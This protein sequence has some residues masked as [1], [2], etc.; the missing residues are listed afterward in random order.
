MRRAG[1]GEIIKGG[2]EPTDQ[3]VR[4]IS[5]SFFEGLISLSNRQS[6]LA[7]PDAKLISVE[8]PMRNIQ[9]LSTPLWS[10][11]SSEGKGIPAAMS[12]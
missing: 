1:I 4:K 6:V 9:E 3:G 8:L 7:P 10:A 2:K 5:Y 12:G 11:L